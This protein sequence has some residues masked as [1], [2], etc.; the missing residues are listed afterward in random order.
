MTI[1][2]LI[3]NEGKYSIEY[4]NTVFPI[5]DFRAITIGYMVKFII[6]KIKK[7]AE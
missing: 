2:K 3:E 7:A 1:I 6:D 4:K 5:T